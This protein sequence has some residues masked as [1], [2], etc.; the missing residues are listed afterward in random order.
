MGYK[1]SEHLQSRKDRTGSRVSK[2]QQK[3]SYNRKNKNQGDKYMKRKEQ[4]NQ[5]EIMALKSK[6]KNLKEAVD[7]YKS[8]ATYK[9]KEQ[10]NKEQ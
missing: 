10:Q 9:P 8:K 4:Y 6:Y 1:I 2:Q 7:Y 3:K 5:E